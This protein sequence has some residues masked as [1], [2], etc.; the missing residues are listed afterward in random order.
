MLDVFPCRIVNVAH[1]SL[2]YYFDINKEIE[3][4]AAT[5]RRKQPSNSLAVDNALWLAK[6]EGTTPAID[7]LQEKGISQSVALRVLGG[8]KFRRHRDR[9]K[10][11]RE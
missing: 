4:M 3:T 1:P 10:A 9:R 11:K 2:S 8:P 7:Y 6:T 5:D